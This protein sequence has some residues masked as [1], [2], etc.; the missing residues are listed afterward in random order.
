MIGDI[1]NHT[2]TKYPVG[3]LQNRWNIKVYITFCTLKIEME[4]LDINFSAHD[5][6][7]E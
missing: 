6:F 7:P 1:T 3:K 5:E 2:S 4:N